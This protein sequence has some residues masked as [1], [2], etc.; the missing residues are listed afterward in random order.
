MHTTTHPQPSVLTPRLLADLLDPGLT[1]NEVAD[2]HQIPP[3]DLPALVAS[4]TFR[5]HAVALAEAESIRETALA[6]LRRSRALHI[7]T[8]ITAQ[9]PT[10]ATHAESVRRAANTLLKET[11]RDGHAH[12]ESA[13]RGVPNP[14]PSS[15]TPPMQS[16]DP[17][18]F[19][20]LPAFPPAA[21]PVASEPDNPDE[22]P[23]E[24]GT[25]LAAIVTSVD[26]NAPASPFVPPHSG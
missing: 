1:L 12:D 6:P 2:R 23:E 20:S 9:E 13:N 18:P 5:A 17:A 22:A 26:P 8:T 10:S 19:P 3:L 4:D 7:L 14:R 11:H 15:V 21:L 24:L 25:L 16:R